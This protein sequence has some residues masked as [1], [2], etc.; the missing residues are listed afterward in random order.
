MAAHL[1]TGCQE[2]SEMYELLQRVAT[3]AASTG[4]D[5]PE[6][7]VRRAESI[8]PR[9]PSFRYETLFPLVAQVVLED[10][11]GKPLNGKAITA[12]DSVYRAGS[13]AVCLHQEND[14][15]SGHISLLGRI[16]RDSEAEQADNRLPVALFSG[17]TIVAR[18]MSNQ[19]GEFS[20]SFPRR[21]ALKIAIAI[22]ATGRRI[23]IPLSRS[24]RLKGYRVDEE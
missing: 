5:V 11:P 23:E 15:L 20:L 18:S 21:P 14:P 19:F 16:S 12:F 24:A 1:Q 2:C 8:F 9:A 4:P 13:L 3:V 22:L 7:L 17:D 10:H 6:D